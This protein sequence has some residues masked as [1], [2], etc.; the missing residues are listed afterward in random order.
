MRLGGLSA[1][2][3]NLASSRGATDVLVCLISRFFLEG[4][5]PLR[6]SIVR[7]ARRGGDSRARVHDRMLR[8]PKHLREPGDLFRNDLGGLLHLHRID[9][10]LLLARGFC[11]QAGTSADLGAIWGLPRSHLGQSRGPCAQVDASNKYSQTPLHLAARLGV[12]AAA[13]LLL[14]AGDQ[15]TSQDTSETPPSN[16]RHV[17]RHP[18]DTF[19]QRW[20]KLF[21]RFRGVLPQ[22]GASLLV[23]DERGQTRADRQRQ[24][25]LCR[26]RTER[27]GAQCA[28]VQRARQ[29][30]RGGVAM[31]WQWQQQK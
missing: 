15:D 20:R 16:R 29:R 10:L 28:A 23:R 17:T 2:L 11:A 14:E 21:G 26:A 8:F 27:A 9:R 22:A 5:N 24:C 25:R 31:P 1:N 13:A 4:P 7:N 6:P 30:L 18:G 19:E 12:P 3:V